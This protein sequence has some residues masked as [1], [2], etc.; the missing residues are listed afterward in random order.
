MAASLSTS[1]SL[2]KAYNA[3]LVDKNGNPKTT[4]ASGYMSNALNS[5][6][7][8]AGKEF[9]GYQD[10]L[11]KD[12]GIDTLKTQASTLGDQVSNIGSRLNAVPEEQKNA[13]RG[14]DVN[15][16]QLNEITAARQAPLTQ[17]LNELT[18]ALSSVNNR[19][20]SAESTFNQQS[21]NQLNLLMTKIQNGQALS[22]AEMQQ[23]ADL[24]KQERDHQNALDLAKISYGNNLG[25][26]NAQTNADIQKYKATTGSPVIISHAPTNPISAVTSNYNST[27]TGKPTGITIGN[28]TFSSFTPR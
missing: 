20:S 6:S 21:Q 13:T 26:I 2:A 14:F 10:A 9:Q 4:S 5:L 24:A 19:L 22:M 23:T 16:G 25:I 15:Q 17:S 3:G 7:G 8:G 28:K 18:P 27:T 11:G 1:K 12:L